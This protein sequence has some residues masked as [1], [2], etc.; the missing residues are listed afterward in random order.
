MSFLFIYQIEDKTYRLV[1]SANKGRRT[2]AATPEPGV[3]GL[4]RKGHGFGE[5]RGKT[6]K[7]MSGRELFEY[8]LR[9]SLWTNDILGTKI[10][11]NVI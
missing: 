7:R 8:F 2:E 11:H 1:M 3:G 9:K 10:E 5:G 6:E 4:A